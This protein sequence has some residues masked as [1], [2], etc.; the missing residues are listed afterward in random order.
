[1]PLSNDER[2]SPSN[3]ASLFCF[4]FFSKNLCIA[5]LRK[6]FLRKNGGKRSRPN[7]GVIFLPL[8]SK[9]KRKNNCDSSEQT[10]CNFRK[11]P[12]LDETNTVF[13][14]YSKDAE[15]KFTSNSK[16]Q[17][18]KLLISSKLVS[19]VKKRFN[20]SPC[21][22]RPFNSSLILIPA[23]KFPLVAP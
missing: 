16:H 7:G 21:Q 20:V 14:L 18:L 23:L 5:G 2:I 19:S 4:Q 11:R 12:F 17:T 10:L 15:L 9:G 22:T 1:M 13:F 3:W 8:L 6:Y